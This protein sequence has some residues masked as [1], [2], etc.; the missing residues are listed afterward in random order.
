MESILVNNL[1][2]PGCFDHDV[3]E[4]KLIETH[5]AWLI[6]TGE[7]VYK[8]KKP[9][10]FGFLD[11]TTLEQRRFYCEEELRL[12]QRMS[13]DLYLEVVTIGG[14][15][16][17]PRIAQ[18]DNPLEYAV[19][20]RQFEGGQLLSDLLEQDR[21]KSEWLEQ[22]AIK[23]A[24]FH[25]RAPIVSPDS[26]WGEADSIRQMSEDNYQQIDKTLLSHED[27]LE[28]E[29]LEQVNAR[30]FA[31]LEHLFRARKVDGYVRECH[32]DLHLGNI[33]LSDNRLVVFDCIEF[34]LEFR[35]I[36]RIADLAFLLMD[37][38]ARDHFRGA[39]L[40]LN[41][42]I[43]HSGD[44]HGSLLLHHY[45]AFRSMIRAKVAMLGETPDLV[46]FR[47]YLRLTSE[48]AQPHKPLLLMMHGCSGT[49]KST[50][51]KELGAH[52][53][54]VRVRSSIERQR[55][56][57]E[58]S[59]QG[60]QIELHGA[61]MDTRTFLRIEQ[62]SEM[63]LRSG[64]T[65]IIDATFLKHR[66]RRRFEQLADRLGCPLRIIA[67]SAPLDVIRQRLTRR[68]LES[69]SET[70]ADFEVYAQQCERA[71]PLNSGEQAIALNA[72]TSESDPSVLA[73]ALATDLAAQGLVVPVIN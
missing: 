46:E 25:T 42:Y 55:I 21:F 65:V 2:D 34:N 52:I 11:F 58:L 24:D 69:D 49:G 14:S 10:N 8:I 16:E 73:A 45:K 37:L 20:L 29:R 9:V 28:L 12:N 27:I 5:I 44:F 67:C 70:E 3:T 31:N 56:Y 53:G 38:E 6:T 62:I 39:N 47:R 59:L 7:Y 40:C 50:L 60:Q 68:Q 57:R 19:K 36:D 22:L 51:A 61:D 30:R 4:L 17:H 15:E 64:Q 43:E 26:I 41:R 33:T 23:V 71:E 1:L 66:T 72:D 54:A 13:S 32:G 48:Y 18:T 35:W 63:L